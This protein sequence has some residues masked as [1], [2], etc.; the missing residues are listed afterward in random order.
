AGRALVHGDV[1]AAQFLAGLQVPVR[2]RVGELPAARAS[3]PLGA[4]ELAAL[5]AEPLDGA[6]E[7]L[8]PLV[9]VPRVPAG[10]VDELAR[11]PLAH[12]RVALGGVEA[13]LVPLL[14]VG[15]LE[16]RH[17][18]VP[19]LEDVLHQ[20]VFGVL[21]EVLYRP[22]RLGR[23]ESLVGVETLDPALGVLLGTR[24]P[25]VRGGV[26]VMH[27]AVYHEVLLAVLLVHRASSLGLHL[28]DDPW[29]TFLA[30]PMWASGQTRD[31]PRR[32]RGWRP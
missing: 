13:L 26:P 19:V 9:A 17:V 20:V 25:V 1:L 32:P 7:H 11:V 2:R 28:G 10:V 31:S 29:L 6:P 18:H 8:E 12:Q 3:V 22:V 15:R 27:V 24:Y 4:V 21:L 14:Q 16:D 30:T 23:T 5:G